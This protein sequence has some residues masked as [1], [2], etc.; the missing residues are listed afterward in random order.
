MLGRSLIK[1]FEELNIEFNAPTRRQ[2]DLSD[3]PA[4][5]AYVASCEPTHLVHAAAMVGGIAA[6]I[7]APVDFLARNLKT[8]LN[9]FEAALDFRVPNLLYMSSSCI[10]PVESD[11]PKTEDMVLAG[12]PEITNLGYALSKIIGMQFASSVATSQSLGWRSLILSNMY[13]PHDH[14]DT[15]KSHLLASIISKVANAID[16]GASEIIMWGDGIA[17]REFTY[18]EDV[19]KFIATNLENI[20]SF[21]Q[22][23]NLGFGE[24]YSVK[25]YYERVIEAFGTQLKLKYDLSK[26][27]GIMQKLMDSSGAK[28]FGWTEL[29]SL[30]IGLRKTVDWY[31]SNLINASKGTVNE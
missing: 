10:Y 25:E 3:G 22:N 15:F 24:D 18:V 14:F 20:A 29:T 2:L 12:K 5:K 7:A 23:M 13:G 16:T 8:D 1:E 17:R 6:N 9:L 27:V 4:V 28:A 11:N 30:D 19:A 31:R 26:P 21:P